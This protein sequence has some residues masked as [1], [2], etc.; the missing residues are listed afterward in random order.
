MR[1]SCIHLSGFKSFAY[2]TV[3]ELDGSLTVIVGPNGSGKSNIVDAIR[4]MLG[5]HS[6]KSLRASSRDDVIFAGSETHP[7]AVQAR[8]ALELTDGHT[9]WIIERFIDREGGGGYA[10]NGQS[11][12]LRDIQE[13]LKGTGL[14]RE[15]YAIVGQGQVEQVA[16]A[17]PETLHALL[18]EAADIAHYK[19]R[20][21]EALVKME[22]TQMNL[23]RLN[24]RLQM[25]GEQKRSLY[26]KAK[27][28]ERN[29]E[30]WNKNVWAFPRRS[31]VFKKNWWKWRV[32]GGL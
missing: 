21:R 19:E 1:L 18:E 28:A 27:R 9:K 22:A 29:S 32:S 26:L 6:L 7:P 12:R 5:E 15:F 10:M 31:K 2:H 16:S 25:L 30:R 11:C 20:K 4:W 23:D 13:L 3:I 17:S 14:G 8:V 24:D